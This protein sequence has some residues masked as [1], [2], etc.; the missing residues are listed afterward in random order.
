MVF[1]IYAV[2]CY[3][4]L[5]MMRK[6]KTFFEG[7]KRIQFTFLL[8]LFI[9]YYPVYSFSSLC[10][11][12]YAGS[13]LYTVGGKKELNESFRRFLRDLMIYYSL[14][15]SDSYPHGINGMEVTFFYNLFQHINK[16][17][18]SEAI[19][20]DG[21]KE[22][23]NVFGVGIIKGLPS[24][25]DL[26]VSYF[27]NTDFNDDM[28]K[29]FISWSIVPGWEEEYSLSIGGNIN[30]I[31]NEDWYHMWGFDMFATLSKRIGRFSPYVGIILTF[32]RIFIYS[33][34]DEIFSDFF[35]YTGKGALGFNYSIWYL[36]GGFQISISNLVHY[37]FNLGINF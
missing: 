32:E 14:D 28:F 35:L 23:Y 31:K 36:K 19:C 34:Y 26:G 11:E 17:Y 18:W 13:Y 3:I 24:F 15:L 29:V 9:F 7:R 21:R 30:Y 22:F 2:A 27:K 16:R 12:D 20:S 1:C 5:R 10:V 6:E 8:L 4:I 33:K 37:I 25:F